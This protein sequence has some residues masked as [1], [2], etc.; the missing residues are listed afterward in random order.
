MKH[1]SIHLPLNKRKEAEPRDR[2][3]MKFMFAVTACGDGG[4]MHISQQ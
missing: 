3:I 4:F 1:N 2:L